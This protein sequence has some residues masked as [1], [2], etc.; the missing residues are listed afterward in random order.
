MLCFKL[1]VPLSKKT[2]D[3]LLLKYESYERVRP[4]LEAFN[5]LSLDTDLKY[6]VAEDEEKK[7]SLINYIKS[8]EKPLNQN[9]D[10][11]LDMEKEIN[12]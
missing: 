6:S 7:T 5:E 1:Y 12:T 3:Q 9:D 10:A 11:K 4:L 2:G 8:E